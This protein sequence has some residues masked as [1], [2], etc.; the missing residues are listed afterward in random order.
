MAEQAARQNNILSTG[1]FDKSQWMDLVERIGTLFNFSEL[2]KKSFS[3][4]RLAKLIG[5]IPFLAGCDEPERTALTNLTIT[6]LASHSA[7]K[8][9]FSHNFS[10]NRSLFKRLDPINNFIG[11]NREIINRALD[12][13]AV[14][15]LSDHKKDLESDL[16]AD[17]YNPLS[18]GIWNFDQ[19]IERIRMRI[20]RYDC[21]E[22]DEIINFQEA[23]A[24]WWEYR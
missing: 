2:E 6:Y 10:D 3:R 4:N 23:L 21:P 15:M 11:G 19:E 1:D 5:S 8:D 22:M 12:L 7:G 20:E 13:L 17:K 9:V 18:S 24:F 16:A 14:I